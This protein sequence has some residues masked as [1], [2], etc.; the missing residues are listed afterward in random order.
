MRYYA[1]FTLLGYGF[2][3]LMG[4]QFTVLDSQ[5]AKPM[6]DVA[7]FWL[8]WYYFGYS[9]VYSTIIAC[10]Q[11][12][13]AVLLC[14]RRTT[15]L[16]ALILLPVMVNIVC[17]DIWVVQFPFDSGA[18]RNA[19]YVFFALLLILAFNLGDIFRFLF[20][21]RDDLAL[22]TKRRSWLLVLEV[23]VVAGILAYTA[24][25]GYWLANVNNRAPTPI[26]GA[27]HVVQIRPAQPDLPDWIYFEYNRAHMTIFHFPDGHSEM[28]DFRVDP[29]DRAL[30]ISKQRLV[31][32]SDIFK[33][34]WDRNGDT[35][36][37]AGLWD[38]R[39][40]IAMTL[41]RKQMPVK[42]HE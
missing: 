17:V 36:T 15:L 38:N 9:P 21:R 8:T 11:I 14:F 41:Q 26:D 29:Q 22:F 42:D 31:P 40:Q 10:T 23:V 33:G 32:G 28:H 5:L 37:L 7:G 3:K 27:W 24:H 35:M 6:G 12:A 13:G 34:A 16:G 39:T 30:T 20:R 1:A 25:E 4:A 19:L 18:L 2:A